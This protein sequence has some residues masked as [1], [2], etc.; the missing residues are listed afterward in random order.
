MAPKTYIFRTYWHQALR[1][2]HVA[3]STFITRDV[4]RLPKPSLL[5]RYAN[6]F[7]AFTLSAIFHTFINI[8]N[9]KEWIQMF[10]FFQSFG[11]AIPLEDAVQALWRRI[12]GDSFAYKDEDVPMWKKIVGFIWVF[13]YFSAV[14]P[15]HIYPAARG[16]SEGDV[17]MPFGEKTTAT[18]LA[19]LGPAIVLVFKPEI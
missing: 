2:P 13:F 17:T 8:G 12:S 16:A 5:E 18:V 14:A 7:V 1:W 9:G 3:L 4:L 6:I 15:W 19:V 11:L 10:C